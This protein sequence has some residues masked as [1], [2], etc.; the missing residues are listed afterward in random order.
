MVKR[1]SDRRPRKEFP[2]Y[3]VQ[4]YNEGSLYWEDIPRA[5]QYQ[6][7]ALQFIENEIQRRK[8]V[9][10]MQVD[11]DRKRHP[12]PEINRNTR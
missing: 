4:T 1:G 12:L 7:E 11:G 5:F 9:R 10:L 8:R 6:D 3:K 2:Y